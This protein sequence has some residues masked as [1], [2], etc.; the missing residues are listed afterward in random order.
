ML[1]MDRALKILLS[2][3]QLDRRIAFCAQ[4]LQTSQTGFHDLRKISLYQRTTVS[5][6]SNQGFATER[7]SG[8]LA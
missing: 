6:R 1:Q 4:L 5:E 3:F 2:I 8:Q 7:L